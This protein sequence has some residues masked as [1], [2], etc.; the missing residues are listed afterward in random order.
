MMRGNRLLNILVR[1]FAWLVAAAVIVTAVVLVPVLRRPGYWLQL[2]HQTFP[3][4]ALALA[5]TPIILTGAIDLSV[6]SMSVLVSI[7]VAALAQRAGWPLELTLG[8]GVLAGL[9][10]GV[11][12]ALLVLLGIPAL[13]ATL[14]TRELYRGLAYTIHGGTSFAAF[15]E[16]RI[17]WWHERVGGLPL[18]LYV[19]AL[20]FLF[21]Y[22]LVHHTWIGRMIY[23]IGDNEEAARF[24]AVP[25]RWIKLG[26][27]ALAGLVSGLCG[28]AA[29]LEYGSARPEMDQTLELA[30]IACVVLGGVRV[31]GGSG[32]VAGTLLGIVT[33]MTLLAAV[34]AAAET[35]RD[36]I[37]GA[38]ILVVAIGNEAAARWVAQRR[39]G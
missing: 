17:G 30:A 36:T 35:W 28:V 25:V 6:G 32:H 21:T 19:I 10:A 38:L 15:P 2:C 13:V 16:A 8:A 18:P 26:L 9:A 34:Q 5:L 23:A 1:H 29:V 22:V 14:A 31:T 37:A 4:A 33:L 7:V 39:S 11:G 12:N 3:I 24:A 20:L 27:F